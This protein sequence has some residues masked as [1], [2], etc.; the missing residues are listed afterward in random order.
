MH[1]NI[2]ID[3]RGIKRKGDFMKKILC[4][5]VALIIIV[6]GFFFV[7]D[8]IGVSAEKLEADARESQRINENWLVSK[9]VS[10]EIAVMVFYPES[11]DDHV[12]SVYAK[13]DS[14]SYGYFFKSGGSLYT[15]EGVARFDFNNTSAYY[16]VNKI[17]VSLIE[18]V[19]PDKTDT[20]EIDSGKPFAFALPDG[21]VYARFF[22]L[23]G[24]EAK[25]IEPPMFV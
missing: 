12:F 11:L 1:D 2:Y 21:A 10:D 22:D 7:R 4:V 15:D 16:S 18:V 5:A 6:F 3:T 25:I 13:S 14:L 23:S 17:G 8:N 19:Y 9:S 20:I 24:N